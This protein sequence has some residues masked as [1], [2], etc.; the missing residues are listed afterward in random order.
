MSFLGSGRG[1]GAVNDIA[2]AIA[3]NEASSSSFE[4]DVQSLNVEFRLSN[5]TI[6]N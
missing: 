1:A 6:G 2:K 3:N 4:D 5:G